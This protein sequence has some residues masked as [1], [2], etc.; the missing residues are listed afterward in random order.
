MKILNYIRIKYYQFFS[1]FID[2]KIRILNRHKKYEDYVN[3]QLEKT[4]DPNRIKK[5]Q[6]EEWQVKVDGF[7]HLF[8]R[9]EEFLQKIFKILKKKGKFFFSTDNI[10]YFKKVVSL[11]PEELS[12]HEHYLKNNLKKNYF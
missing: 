12:R 3:K 10:D 2:G 1:K 4:L 9:N 8:K 6:A 7:R 5:W 11:T